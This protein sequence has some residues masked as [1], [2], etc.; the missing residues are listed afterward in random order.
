MNVLNTIG[1][2]NLVLEIIRLN[3]QNLLEFGLLKQKFSVLLWFNRGRIVFQ[4]SNNVS[5]NSNK[6]LNTRN[7]PT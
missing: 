3:G 6:F 2:L 7:K 5:E 4:H 1:E